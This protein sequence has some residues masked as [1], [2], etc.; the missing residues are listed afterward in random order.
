MLSTIEGQGLCLQSIQY[1][2]PVLI[3]VHLL[4]L[5][6]CPHS[7]SLNKRPFAVAYSREAV[8]CNVNASRTENREEMASEM[9]NVGSRDVPN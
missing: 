1:G 7:N 8:T 2:N 5:G 6:Q 3:E 9:C 4:H